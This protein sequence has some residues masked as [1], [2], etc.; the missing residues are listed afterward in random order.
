MAISATQR[1]GNWAEQRALR[2]LQR[3][4]WRLLARQWRC[5]WGELDL[6]LHKPQRL[7]LVE[8]KSRRRCGPDGWGAASFDAA[9]RA[10]LEAAYG[11]WL[12]AHPRYQRCSLELVLALVPQPPAMAPVRWIRWWG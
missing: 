1:S 3:S 8:V 11:C 7:L 5:R 2:L 10:R 9:K 12:A 4:G 6:L